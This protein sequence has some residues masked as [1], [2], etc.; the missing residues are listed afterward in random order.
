MILLI[1]TY[2][3][4]KI[5]FIWHTE[6]NV[7]FTYLQEGHKIGL[8]IQLLILMLLS[9]IISDSFNPLVSLSGF[10]HPP[11]ILWY[12]F[13]IYIALSVVTN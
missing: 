4:I 10:Y 13:N 2:K 1:Q 7:I 8:Y 11:Q 5:K 12:M 9:N 6:F 3:W